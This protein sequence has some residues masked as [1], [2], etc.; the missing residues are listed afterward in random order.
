M[1]K[2]IGQSLRKFEAYVLSQPNSKLMRFLA[3]GLTMVDM[4]REAAAVAWGRTITRVGEPRA[5]L[6]ALRRNVHRLEKGMIMQPRRLP[7][8]KDY[9][10]ETVTAFRVLD[11][12]GD[13]PAEDREWA[14]DVLSEYFNINAEVDETWVSA[15]QKAFEE[16][17]RVVPVPVLVPFARKNSPESTITITEL[18]TLAERRRSVRWFT[19]VEVSA[20]SIDSA[21]RVAG[22]APS[23]C[24]RQNIRFHII[25]GIEASEAVLSTVGGTRGFKHQVPAVAVVIGRLAGYRHTFDRHAIYVDGGLASMGFLY[26]LEAQGLSS[27]CINW[28]DV[29]AQIKKIKKIVPLAPD[30]QVVMLIAI[31][32]ADPEALIPRSH[33]R[34]LDAFR[35][36]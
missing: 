10:P 32:H 12:A 34:G 26:G 5:D 27:C 19:P 18:Q 30:E 31:G 21:L 36:S 16:V 23:A 7:F 13:L 29:G 28:P 2:R 17:A 33:K 14:A 20:D 9:L 1:K 8:G 6:T 15:A 4:R 3:I 25:Q 11:E 22:Q 24:N 35:T